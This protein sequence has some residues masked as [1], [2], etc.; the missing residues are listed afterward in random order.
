MNE[1][2]AKMLKDDTPADLEVQGQLDLVNEEESEIVNDHPENL[3]VM[4][5]P[6]SEWFEKHNS[7]FDDINQVK[8][9]IRGVDPG[10]TIIITIP[11]PKNEK[12]E[13]GNF[14]RRVK[15]FEDSDQIPVIDLTPISMDIYN[16]G[17]RIIYNCNDDTSI[18]CYGVKN[19][20]IAVL[21]HNVD[22][23]MIPYEIIKAKKKEKDLEITPCNYDEMIQNLEKPAN[24]ENIQILYAQVTKYISDI[25]TN[26]DAVTWFLT[27]QS[28]VADV[29][30]H[31]Q[32]DEV[33]CYILK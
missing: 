29:N 14:K 3:R 24:K 19:G 11:D 32:I 33:I 2:L 22:N 13:S 4:I 9:A 27:R 25:N 15:I 26:H 23:Q 30:H 1:N 28:E 21:C 7:R 31:L 10:K 12:D 17:F 20:L 5:K 18:K 8:V 16:N 6:F